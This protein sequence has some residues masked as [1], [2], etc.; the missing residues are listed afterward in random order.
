MK[1]IGSVCDQTATNAGAVNLLAYPNLRKVQQNGQLFSYIVEGN[2]II[3][4]FDPPHIL[5]VIRNNL[6]SKDLKHFVSDVWDYNSVNN[7]QVK[8]KASLA[9]WDDVK[10]FHSINVCNT[11]RLLRKI[12][13]EHIDPKRLKMKVYVAAQIFSNTFGNIMMYCSKQ[14]Q[15]PRDMSGTAHILI[16]F[17]NLFDSLN[18][19]GKTNVNPLRSSINMNNYKK[20]LEF[21]NYANSMLEK[22]NFIEKGTGKINNNSSVLKKTIS[23]IKGYIELTKLCLSSGIKSLSLRQMNQDGLENF[24]G[25]IRSFCHT[26]KQPMPFQ[27]RTAFTSLIVNNLTAKHSL[28]S[29]CLNDKNVALLQDVYDFYDMDF[30]EVND[31][32][33]DDENIIE[34]EVDTDDLDMNFFETEAIVYEASDVCRKILSKTKCVSC[35]NTLE[36]SCPLK[37]HGMLQECE[38]TSDPAYQFFTYPT[39][40]FLS[41]FKTLYKKIEILLPLICHENTMSCNLM[42]SVEH[43]S[44]AGLGCKEHAEAISQIIKKATVKWCVNIFTKQINDILARKTLEHPQDQHKIHEKAFEIVKKR[45]GVGK[46]GQVPLL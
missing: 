40:L 3:H 34:L 32:V 42:S 27:F 16:F 6:I 38:I 28:R 20:C 22:M 30:E 11:T 35:R 10:K 18:G 37:P 21:W 14:K 29:N 5:K 23:T 8:N 4:C 43:F 12:T 15:L 44:L 1:I 39:L 24:F 2:A 19:A 13:D 33:D 31:E 45:R 36:A 46:F 9:S 25:N 41:K 7:T 17:N 26:K